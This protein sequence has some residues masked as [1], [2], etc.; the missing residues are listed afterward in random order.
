M[1]NKTINVLIILTILTG[2]LS[3][4]DKFIRFM[5]KFETALK[6][7]ANLFATVKNTVGTTLW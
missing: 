4:G 6:G 2:L 1:Q 5:N 3:C 7:V